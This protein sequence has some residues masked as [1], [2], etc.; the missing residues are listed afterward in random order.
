MTALGALLALAGWL[1]LDR[2]MTARRHQRVLQVLGAA[3]LAGV[4]A[5]SIAAWGWRLG[6]VGWL[7]LLSA[8]ALARVF[9]K[10]YMR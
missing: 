5:A 2:A 1:A 8:T 4:F 9:A 6:P 10:P 7:G 3:A